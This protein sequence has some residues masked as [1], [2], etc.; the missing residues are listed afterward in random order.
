[1]QHCGERVLDEQEAE[2]LCM[3]ARACACMR[4]LSPAH[5]CHGHASMLVFAQILAPFL[6]VKWWK[7]GSLE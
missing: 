4:V 1:M 5:N 6:D 7:T 2:P 3:H